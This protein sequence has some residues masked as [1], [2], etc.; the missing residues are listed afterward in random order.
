MRVKKKKKTY[1]QKVKKSKQRKN[2]KG[3]LKILKQ[4]TN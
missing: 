4:K 2:T 1:R 3:L